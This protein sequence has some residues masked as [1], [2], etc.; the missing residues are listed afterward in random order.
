MPDASESV[1]GAL[2]DAHDSAQRLRQMIEGLLL[3]S[4]LEEPTFA[5]QREPVSVDALLREIAGRFATRAEESGVTI[6]PPNVEPGVALNADRNLLLRVVENILDKALRHT[7]RNGR[8]AV[9]AHGGETV[10]I[11]ISNTG[12]RIP[13]SDRGR[14]FENFSRGG[15]AT[16]ANVGLGLYFCRRAVEAHGGR[17][18][19]RETD[20]WPTSF[21]V[22]LPADE[23][24]M[25]P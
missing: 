4:R 11:A 19:V 16:P 5:L 9:D 3:I 7:P 13:P 6:A 24:A 20:E 25:S 14:I 2:S 8:V 1:R 17:I 10:E 18:E 23:A 21:V 12:T 15:E 22:R